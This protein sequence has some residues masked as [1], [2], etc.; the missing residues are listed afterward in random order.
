MIKKQ[1]NRL[2]TKK[3]DLEEC[4][5][6]VKLNIKNNNTINKERLKNGMALEIVP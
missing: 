5:V 2:N 6:W 3:K 4:F 1:P